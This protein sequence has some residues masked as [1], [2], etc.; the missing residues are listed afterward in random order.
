MQDATA[1]AQRIAD[2]VL[3]PVEA[4]EA[5][6]AAAE[7]HRDL[8]AICRI[9]PDLG[10]AAAGGL[11]ALAADQRGPLHGVPMLGKDLGSAAAGLGTYAGSPALQSRLPDPDYDS[12]LFRAFK[13]TGLVPFGLT[14]VPE[15]GLAL[16]SEPPGGPVARNPWNPSRTPGG[17]SGGSAAAVASG[18]VGIAHATDAAGSTRV[19]AAYCGLVGMK[20]TRGATP[21]GPDFPNLLLGIAGELVLARSVRDVATVFEGCV[22]RPGNPWP[23]SQPTPAKDIVRV[24]VSIPETVEAEQA[25]AVEAAARMLEDL[26][27]TVIDGP[28]LD[29][30]GAD[31]LDFARSIF[32]AALAH[33]LDMLGVPETEISPLGAAILEEGRRMSAA[34]LFETNQAMARLAYEA[35]ALFE[36]I[37]V[38]LTPTVGGPAPK[39]G[40]FPADET[41]ADTRYAMMGA[42]AP[43]AAFANVSGCPAIALPWGLDEVGMPLSVQLTGPMGS[44]RTLLKLAE[45]LQADSPPLPFPETIAGLA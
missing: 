18:I 1:L 25:E 39:I 27:H 28:S 24:G 22:G 44:D 12:D 33:G 4:M 19:P 7:R 16:T 30:L 41:N 21:M 38:L 14:T 23:A 32:T 17:S 15:F 11:D 42:L 6:M 35:G 2:G 34:D 29:R 45:T 31:A 5:A 8:G 20:A 10:I 13:R 43:N 36:E 26:G 40:H 37:D 9:D 3:S